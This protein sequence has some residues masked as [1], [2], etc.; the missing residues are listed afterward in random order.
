MHDHTQP[1]D[2]GCLL[3]C[4]VCTIASLLAW[5]ALVKTTLW[6]LQ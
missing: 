6:L 1:K 2:H 3:G 4:I 5:L